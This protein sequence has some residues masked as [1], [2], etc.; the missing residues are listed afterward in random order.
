[1][2]ISSQPLAER[3]HYVTLTGL[4]TWA[5]FQAFLAQTEAQGLLTPG[6]VRVLIHLDH[7]TGWESGEHWGDISFFCRHDQEIDRIAVVGEARWRDEMLLFLFGDQ[8]HAETRFFTD[9]DL[10]A[11][12]A[13]LLG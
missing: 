3:A 4:L 8:R 2:A 1:M 9:S 5:D 12:R 10:T 11:A 6:A 7:F 13:W